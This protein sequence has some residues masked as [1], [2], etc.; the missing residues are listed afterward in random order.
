MTK[1]N[2]EQLSQEIR[3]M[4]RTHALYRVLRDELKLLGFWKYRK[5]GD[6][7]KGYKAMRQVESSAKDF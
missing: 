2:L 5:R 6:P 3:V 7:S 4:N 1:I